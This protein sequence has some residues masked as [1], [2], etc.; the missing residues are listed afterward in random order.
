MKV[1]AS[2]PRTP[3]ATVKWMRASVLSEGENDTDGADEGTDE[4]TPDGS[5]VGLT[6]GSNDAF[7]VYMEPNPT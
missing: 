5:D 6:E 4:G 7:I 2:S 1:V 3:C